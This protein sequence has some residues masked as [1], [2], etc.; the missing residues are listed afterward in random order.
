MGRKKRTGAGARTR[1]K[2]QASSCLVYASHH[3]IYMAASSA[4][5]V[6]AP[7]GVAVSIIAVRACAYSGVF[8]P[9]AAAALILSAAPKPAHLAR[10]NRSLVARARRTEGK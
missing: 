3:E 9:T 5:P 4:W 10:P 7:I 6:R 1:A 2:H 8:S